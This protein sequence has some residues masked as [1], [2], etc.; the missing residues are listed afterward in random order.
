M[1]NEETDA[2]YFEINWNLISDS[3]REKLT[4]EHHDYLDSIKKL[5][6]VSSVHGADVRNLFVTLFIVLS[7]SL[8]SKE[9]YVII[10]CISVLQF[11]FSIFSRLALNESLFEANE[12]KKRFISLIESIQDNSHN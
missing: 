12:S 3:D 2:A 7:L 10:M 5:N 6:R 4:K 8:L 1:S 11:I 9:N